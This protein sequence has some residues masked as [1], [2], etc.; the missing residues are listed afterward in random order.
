MH[1]RRAVCFALALCALLLIGCGEDDDPR[2]PGV[3][4]PGVAGT[5]M[6]SAQSVPPKFRSFVYFIASFN[7]IR[8]D[9]GT[10]TNLSQNA[11]VAT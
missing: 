11:M 8:L 1:A 5:S 10:G 9:K 3:G 7:L 2:S 4:T 6:G